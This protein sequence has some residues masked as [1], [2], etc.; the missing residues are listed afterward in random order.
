[1]PISAT[2][3]ER[4]IFSNNMIRVKWAETD[5]RVARGSVSRSSASVPLACGP[6]AGDK[7]TRAVSEVLC[8]LWPIGAIPSCSAGPGG[9]KKPWSSWCAPPGANTSHNFQAAHGIWWVALVFSKQQSL[10]LCHWSSTAVSSGLEKK[11]KKY[12]QSGNVDFSSKNW[13]RKTNC[14]ILI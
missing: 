2:G 6:G 11:K 8:T 4:L 13:N 12:R 7:V 5:N 1:M 14:R 3:K 9:K 10:E